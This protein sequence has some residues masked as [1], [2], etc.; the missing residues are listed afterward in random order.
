MGHRGQ[1][2]SRGHQES[3]QSQSVAVRQKHRCRGDDGGECENRVK[4][5]IGKKYLI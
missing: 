2:R 4:C 1:A 3:A 5:E